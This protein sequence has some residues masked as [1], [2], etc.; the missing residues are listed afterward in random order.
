M[1]VLA[2]SDVESNSHFIAYAAGALARGRHRAGISFSGG[3]VCL[4]ICP[5]EEGEELRRTVE[6]KIS[7]IICI[8]YKYAQLSSSVRP[9]GLTDEERE[10]LLAALIAADFTEDKKYVLSR[11]RGAKEYSVDGFFCFRL[12]DLREKWKGVAACVPPVFTA[13]Q[14]T[15]FMDFLLDGERGKIFLKGGEVYDS[16]CRRLRRAALIECGSHE[17][18][19][20]REIVLSCAAKVECLGTLPEREER[21]LRRYYAG[22]VGFR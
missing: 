18:D 8:G 17:L 7:E 16:R 10:I 6:E 19:T 4:R 2:V 9:A 1:E 3:R 14:L 12:R 11:L 15:A 13:G 21:F 5:E 20:L 22:R